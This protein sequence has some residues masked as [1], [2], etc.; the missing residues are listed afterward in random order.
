MSNKLEALYNAVI[1]KPIEVD[2]TT[3]G[4]IIVPDMGKEVNE[5]G[6]VVA[7]GPGQFSQSGDLLPTVL[8]VGDKVVLPTMGFTKLPFDGEEYYVG[9]E[10]QILAKVNTTIPVEE[11]LNET[12]LTE[13]DEKNL[14]DIKNN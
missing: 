12:K 7:V 6:E 11:V 2:E 4:N 10:N 1:V 3:Y 9:P 5:F 13:E 8:K 14:T